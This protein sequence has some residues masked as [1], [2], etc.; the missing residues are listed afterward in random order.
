MMTIQT[1]NNEGYKQVGNFVWNHGNGY[2]RNEWPHNSDVWFNAVDTD[3]NIGHLEIAGRYSRTG[4][5]V[6]ITFGPECF[7]SEEIAD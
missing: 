4:N 6:T 1:L 5:P 2:V 3:T 7:D